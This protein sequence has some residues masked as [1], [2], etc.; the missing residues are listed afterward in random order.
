MNLRLQALV[1]LVDSG[2]RVAD[3]GT[4]HAYLPIALFKQQRAN[5]VIASDVG[6]GP[7]ANAQ[8]DIQAAG[9]EN[10]IKT[11][12]GS[13]LA[14][15]L[16]TDRINTAVIAGMGGRLITEI[17]Q[18]GAENGLLLPTLVLAPNVGEPIVRHWLMDHHYQIVA[19]KLLT[20]A[21]HSYELIKAKLGTARFALTESELLFG[22]YILKQR[23][24][25]FQKKW[26]DR[27]AYLA[28]LLTN[29]QRAKKP[30]THLIK[31]V[32]AEQKLIK[33]ILSDDHS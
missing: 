21:G 3:I 8:A 32:V 9:L 5:F 14:T 7:L 6:K 16:P 10:Q 20:E 18:A 19:E 15:I 27:A 26:I 12:L 17:L 2:A 13:G 22:P 29:L 25:I 33:E 11:R 31:Q 4:D 1:E 24:S 30:D 28:K 23:G